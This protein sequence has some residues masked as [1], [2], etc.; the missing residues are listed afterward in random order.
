METQ[1]KIGDLAKQT[2]VAVGTLRYWSDLRLLQPVKKGN[3]GYRYYGEDASQQ[4]QFIKKAQAIGF[5]LEEIKT[6]L[7]VKDRGEQPCSLV[8][9][10]LA[11]KIE[12]L[13]IQIAKMNSFKEEL[14]EYRTRWQMQP[15]PKS[16]SQEVCPLISSVSLD[17][18]SK[19]LEDSETK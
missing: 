12:Q 1:L 15:N 3:N 4:V 9:S 8:Q 17:N 7:D 18:H 11:R 2:G 14:E 19:Q 16:K 5:T 6:I 13:E 10:L